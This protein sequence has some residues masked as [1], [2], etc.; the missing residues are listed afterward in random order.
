MILHYRVLRNSKI[1]DDLV[2]K[3]AGEMLHLAQ[4]VCSK[5]Y[6]LLGTASDRC[7]ICM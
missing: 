5:L 3:L 1:D 4:Q 7:S 6:S 2:V